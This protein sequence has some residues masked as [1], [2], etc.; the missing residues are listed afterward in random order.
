M[1]IWSFIREELSENNNVMLIVVVERNGSSPGVVG[2]K[3]A[4]SETGS[5][6]GSIGGGVMEYNMVELAKKAAKDGNQKA[7]IK[8]QN[9]NP[10][11]EKDKSGLICS[12][13]QTHAF[14]LLDKSKMDIINNIVIK[15]DIR[16][17]GALYL[18]Q[19]GITF[20]EAKTLSS[21]I[22]YNF[23]D[24]N[25]WEYTEQIGLKP[26]LYIFGAGHVSLPMSQIFRVLDFTVVVYDNRDEL[27]TFENNQFA[28]RKE[29]VDFKDISSLVPEGENS[30]AVIMTVGHKSDELVLKQLA[31]KNLKYL[32][33]IGSKNKVKTIHDSLINKGISEADLAKVDSPI[34]LSINSKSTAEIA[35]SIAAKIIQV[36]NSNS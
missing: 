1:K 29:I 11:A 20:D 2:F 21:R 31:T 15:L 33:M 27:S 18:N 32:G 23:K 16:E 7:F 3:M 19:D 28:H 26:T 8:R 34:G 30:Y 12:G 9:H 25:D 17:N 4:V 14:I 5:M 35:I 13:E 24:E 36:K 10:D 6:S 22:N